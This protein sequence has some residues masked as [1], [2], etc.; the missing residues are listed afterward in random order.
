MEAEMAKEQRTDKEQELERVLIIG[1]DPCSWILTLDPDSLSNFLIPGSDHW[2]WLFIL[3]FLISSLSFIGH[4]PWYW[5]LLLIIVPDLC[6]RSWLMN[7]FFTCQ[8]I[9]SPPPIWYRFATLKWSNSGSIL[10]WEIIISELLGEWPLGN[11]A[12]RLNLQWG[13]SFNKTVRACRLLLLEKM[14]G[15]KKIVCILANFFLVLKSVCI[16]NSLSPLKNQIYL[17]V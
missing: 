4:N 17:D 13:E 12:V 1:L 11:G 9:F 7:S 10:F 3:I 14:G 5:S 6:S 15:L 16:M 2:S 8:D